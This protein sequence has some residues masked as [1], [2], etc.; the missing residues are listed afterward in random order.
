MIRPVTTSQS[1]SDEEQDDTFD[2]TALFAISP[3]IL[4]PPE[5][6][7]RIPATDSITGYRFYGDNIDKNVK[8]R[9]LRSDK[10]G[11]SIHY[12]HSFAVKDP[13]DFTH[14][15]NTPLQRALP[16]PR[17][18]AKSL[19]PSPED[20][21]ALAKNLGTIVSRILTTHMKYFN[22]TFDGVTERHI[23]HPHSVEMQHKSTVVSN[24]LWCPVIT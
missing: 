5:I 7:H 12:F 18:I 14:L 11:K 17:A 22:F 8:A 24:E 21:V 15:P 6:I 3:T 19:L 4:H 16:S 20:D 23:Q 10:R 13:I 2:A 9:Y 1:S